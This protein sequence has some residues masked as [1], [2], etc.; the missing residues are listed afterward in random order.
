M[1]KYRIH[2]LAKLECERLFGETAYEYSFCLVDKYGTTY[3]TKEGK[4]PIYMPS[5]Y[6]GVR[7]MEAYCYLQA[8]AE[9]ND[10]AFKEYDA[11][12][13]ASETHM[14]LV[15]EEVGIFEPILMSSTKVFDGMNFAK[16][17]R[18]LQNELSE[19]MMQ[20]KEVEKR[21]G[22]LSKLIEKEFEEPKKEQDSINIEP[23][24]EEKPGSFPAAKEAMQQFVDDYK[25]NN[26]EIEESDIELE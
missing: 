23:T 3:K 18:K 17:V 25:D 4:I 13:L 12:T 2:E 24:S 10:I 8:Y 20:I 9:A 22:K 26:E 11:V 6:A 5:A 1:A 21:L 16:P 15:I 7:V 19:L 14:E